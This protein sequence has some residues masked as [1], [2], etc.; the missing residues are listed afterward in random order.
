MDFA[1]AAAKAGLGF[2]V[3]T[4]DWSMVPGKRTLTNASYAILKADCKKHTT[5]TLQL[6]PGVAI[7]NNIGNRQIFIGEGF[8]G[9]PPN[10]LTE[11]GSQLLLQGVTARTGPPVPKGNYSGFNTP[12]FNWMLSAANSWDNHGST[13]VLGA[14]WTV[15][16][17][18]LGPTVR[19]KVPPHPQPLLGGYSVDRFVPYMCLPFR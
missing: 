4:E 7:E 19:A 9:F 14:G 15:G 2:V 3:F 6:I 16:Y 18:Q 13:A 1:A 10:V 11:D 12:S 17:H 8:P 5:K